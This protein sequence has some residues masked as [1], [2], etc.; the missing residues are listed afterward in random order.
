L[1]EAFEGKFPSPFW[2]LPLLIIYFLPGSRSPYKQVSM[3][4]VAHIS[5]LDLFYRTPQW[6][7]ELCP[8]AYSTVRFPV[9]QTIR[10]LSS[11][12]CREH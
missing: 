2:R 6:F 5:M 9:K 1:E 12:L 8:F 3:N 10:S 11:G 4:V 7:C